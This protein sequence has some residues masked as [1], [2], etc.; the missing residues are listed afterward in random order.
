MKT[1]RV[2]H[3]SSEEQI[4]IDRMAESVSRTE[5]EKKLSLMHESLRK[6]ALQDPKADS[7]MRGFAMLTACLH[8]SLAFGLVTMTEA[9]ECER[10][11]KH[12]LHTADWGER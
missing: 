3:L 12:A 2:I 11:L 7:D 5:A 10:W 8:Y 1:P 9:E 6:Y 4:A